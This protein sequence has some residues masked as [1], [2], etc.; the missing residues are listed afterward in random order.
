MEIILYLHYTKITI[1]KGHCGGQ[2][3]SILMSSFSCI[4]LMGAIPYLG[5]LKLFYITGMAT[6]PVRGHVEWRQSLL[7]VDVVELWS[8]ISA[9]TTLLWRQSTNYSMTFPFTLRK[10][11]PF[12]TVDCTKCWWDFFKHMGCVSVQIGPLLRFEHGVKL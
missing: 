12:I 1:F 6:H 10:R 8:R 11:Y 4:S 9:L 3:V 5:L 7:F 2:V